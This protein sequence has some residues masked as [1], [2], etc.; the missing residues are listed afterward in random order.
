M[1]YKKAFLAAG[2][3]L[4]L[5]ALFYFHPASS[6]S[7]IIIGSN[8]RTGPEL[9]FLEGCPVG[10][11]CTENTTLGR[12]FGRAVH[13]IQVKDLDGDGINETSVMATVSATAGYYEV[14]TLNCD[15]TGCYLV[16]E[17]SF[18][19]PYGSTAG[20]LGDRLAYGN[21]DN[22]AD[23]SQELVIG[24][25]TAS[26]AAGRWEVRVLE[27]GT[28]NTG[29][30]G[31]NISGNGTSY[32]FRGA[33]ILDERR[34]FVVGD[35]GAAYRWDGG[36]WNREVLSTTNNTYD[37]SCA[38]SG[39]NYCFAGGQAGFLAYWNGTPNVW[40]KTIPPSA[41][42]VNRLALLNS[43]FGFAAI[44]TV[45]ATTNI[46]RWNGT[47]WTA[48]TTPN[49]AYYAID[50]LNSTFGWA[51]GTSGIIANWNGTDWVSTASPTAAT[52]N[53]IHIWNATHAF[54]STS[55]GQLIKWDGSSWAV[56]TTPVATSI[57]RVR[58]FNESFA[59]AV[60]GTALLDAFVW[61]GS[62][63]TG[64]WTA[65]FTNLP[66][67]AVWTDLAVYRNPTSGQTTA[68]AVG[69]LGI[70]AKYS[71]ETRKCHE[72]QMHTDYY[73]IVNSIA[74]ADINDDGANELVVAGGTYSA[75]A[76]QNELQ[77]W[78][79]TTGTCVQSYSGNHDFRRTIGGFYI[80]D[81]DGDGA[82][83][84]LAGQTSSSTT[85]TG[86]C[87]IY[88]L[89]AMRC[90]GMVCTNC[91][92][93]CRID[94]ALPT[95]GISYGVGIEAN[96]PTQGRIIVNLDRSTGAGNDLLIYKMGVAN[97]G[98]ANTLTVSAGGLNIGTGSAA[99]QTVAHEPDVIPYLSG[100]RA[101]I[102]A[103]WAYLTNWTFGLHECPDGTAACNYTSWFNA[104][105]ATY[106]TKYRDSVVLTPYFTSS[107]SDGGSD[108]S[109]PTTEAEYVTFSGTATTRTGN[110]W[111]L[112]VCNYPDVRSGNC[113]SQNGQLC[114][115][116]ATP[117]AS[118]ATCQFNT[119]SRSA[120]NYSW[121][122]YACDATTG[123]CF[124]YSQS[125][126]T[127]ARP[128]FVNARPVASAVSISPSNPSTS[129]NLLCYGTVTDETY[130]GTKAFV[131]W[132]KNGANQ[133]S[134]FRQVS[135]TNGSN[136]LLFT[137]LS[138][139]LTIGDSWYCSVVP[140][141]GFAEGDPT[142]ASAVE[143]TD[144]AGPSASAVSSNVSSLD[145]GAAIL[146]SAYWTDDAGLSQAKLET[147]ETGSLQNK[148][149]YGSP[150]SF[151]TNPEW[152][153]FTWENSS[154]YPDNTI[155]WRI[156]AED[157]SSNWG[158]TSLQT[159]NVRDSS[160]PVFGSYFENDSAPPVGGT[161]GLFAYWTD[162]F[163]LSEAKLETN[164]TGTYQNKTTYG[165][166]LIFFGAGNWSNFTW[167][168]TSV[169]S[170]TKINW[171]IWAKDASGNWNVT[172]YE[173][174]LVFSGVDSTP[175][176][177]YSVQDNTTSGQAEFGDAIKLASF[178]QDNI[179]LEGAKL[180]T[181]ETGSWG[182]ASLLTLSG[183]NDW[184][185]FTWASGAVSVNQVVGWRLWAN[186]TSGNWNVT[187]YSAFRIVDTTQPAPSDQGQNNSNP[188]IGETLLLYSY[189][190]DTYQLSGAKLETNET[191]S[192]VNYS[193]ISLS[194]TS[195]WSNFSWS[196]ASLLSGAE[197]Y[198]RIWAN[199][200]SGNWNVTGLV[201]FTVID[202]NSPA[203]RDAG[204]NSSRAYPGD[205]LLIYAQG[206]DA[207]L[208]HALLSTN[209]TGNWANYSEEYSSPA[210]LGTSNSWTWSNFTWQN[211]SASGTI[212]WSIWYNDSSGNWNKTS[213]QSFTIYEP[214]VSASPATVSSCGYAYYRTRIYNSSDELV[215]ANLVMRL[216]NPAG[217]IV[218]TSN[219]PSSSLPGGI[220]CG[221]FLLPYGPARGTWTAKATSSGV[222]SNRTFLVGAGGLDIWQILIDLSL[223]TYYQS[224]NLTANFTIYNLF[225][226]GVSALA[227]AE[228]MSAFISSTQLGIGNVTEVGSGKYNLT[229]DLSTFPTGSSYLEISA[230]S[231]GGQTVTQR[232]G[233]L[234]I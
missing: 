226:E 32:N 107:P 19:F 120:G 201:K 130:T 123:Q 72:T 20:G 153:N 34:A 43:T 115:S 176:K 84:I 23:G 198:W 138:G 173:S 68:L 105:V 135:V 104:T 70:A 56:D 55:T 37:V 225:G 79:C 215:S 128:F 192:F 109:A 21:V 102:L 218:S 157:S 82:T 14:T 47:T 207:E 77:L 101:Q 195:S 210:Y 132:I 69:T 145:Y 219:I 224:E 146:L 186:D 182:N 114:K 140:Y 27:C 2:I 191:G 167:R 148:T 209:E 169:V 129:T 75:T 66:R 26:T 53:S 49:S 52:I 165:S 151:S 159:F 33:A 97:G 40:T 172:P 213:D 5:L 136:S 3:S 118:Q 88:E 108:H 170:G 90:S 223:P 64:T 42:Q 61:Q 7:K 24:Q 30:F 155:Q 150:F 212:H 113:Q 142:N 41:T 11:T 152:A 93:N 177:Y 9:L 71:N 36:A 166:P 194:G 116:S 143:V 206:Y 81:V 185:N 181:N 180:E 58:Y 100:S 50:L 231:S 139:N 168:N 39:E 228:N 230:N 197:I 216:L 67:T 91:G 98:S 65:N 86:T 29:W 17:M 134:L 48:M 199:D 80:G 117:S 4:V 202:T 178:W 74:V 111:N 106:V 156:W 35:A 112:V 154:I 205:T 189:W 87:G 31:L 51:G 46:W 149:V 190:Q 196:N 184:S 8:T 163:N 85:A 211:E 222:S 174:F 1:K 221:A 200:T 187:G 63:A 28:N 78:N 144:Q 171:R 137:V 6:L 164:E 73:G 161:V 103:P 217:S 89:C 94:T 119:S 22:S 121:F 59:L 45:A 124:N 229:Y 234:V 13:D 95:Y 110:N 54:G 12:E 162:N 158:A 122:A 131:S 204:S 10:S 208:S 183:Q 57:S 38:D 175:P 60:P 83:E 99:G 147:N 179:G 15:P 96:Q 233:F 76:N 214:S 141:D 160:E 126:G 62:G 232:K 127:N 188:N 193:A 25:N 44:N 92:A 220:Y 203:I 16:P 18:D 133:T 227:S 125:T